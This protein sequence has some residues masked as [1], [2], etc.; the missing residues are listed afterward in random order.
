M[1]IEPHDMRY[2]NTCET[3][4]NEAKKIKFFRFTKGRYKKYADGNIN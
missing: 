3:G 2:Q 1:D 4:K